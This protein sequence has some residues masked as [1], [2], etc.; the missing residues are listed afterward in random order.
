MAEYLFQYS[1]EPVG[2]MYSG[3]TLFP[4]LYRNKMY[5]KSLLKH[6]WL[7]TDVD[8]TYHMVDNVFYVTRAYGDFAFV[9]YVPRYLPTHVAM[10]EHR[11]RVSYGS[12][13]V[14]T[15]RKSVYTGM[16]MHYSSK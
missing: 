10:R 6:G 14:F 12:D 9:L 13:T 2:I 11:R 4:E 3:Y 8:Q 15:H 5:E 7:Y 1:G 16:P